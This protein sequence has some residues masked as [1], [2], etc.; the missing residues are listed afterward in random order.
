VPW[1]H[2][3]PVSRHAR[4]R[5]AASKVVTRAG[6]RVGVLFP[7]ASRLLILLI[8]VSAD[9]LTTGTGPVLLMPSVPTPASLQARLVGTAHPH[10]CP[11]C[12][13]QATAGSPPSRKSRNMCGAAP[14]SFCPA[15]C[16]L[17]PAG[18]LYFWR[19]DVQTSYAEI[20]DSSA[21]IG[22]GGVSPSRSRFTLPGPLLPLRGQDFRQNLLRKIAADIQNSCA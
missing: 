2:G 20:A 4:P 18:V 21:P 19:T 12:S 5:A 10:R 11:A 8:D 22:H 16:W 14:L 13:S 17:P 15:V 7:A 9:L 3:W 1:R 6:R